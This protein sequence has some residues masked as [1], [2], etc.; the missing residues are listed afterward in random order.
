V[1]NQLNL[2][3]SEYQYY[4]TI[5]LNHLAVVE[6]LVNDDDGLFQLRTGEFDARTLWGYLQ[7]FPDLP[8]DMS[9]GGYR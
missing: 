7:A 2:P 1:L 6:L 8:E 5:N 4:Q 9:L 3:L